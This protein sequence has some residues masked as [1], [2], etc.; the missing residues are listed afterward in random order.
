M[1]TLL[2]DALSGLYSRRGPTLVAASGLMLAMTACL[3]VALLA[4]ALSATDPAIPD[5]ERVVLLDMK[6]NPPGQPSP[7]FT[8]SPVSFADMLKQRKVPLDLVSRALTDGLDIN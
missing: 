4:I 8:A 1:K 2:L 6:G 7:W 5:P 3:L